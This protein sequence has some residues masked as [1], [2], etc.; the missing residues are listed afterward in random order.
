MLENY[1]K[2]ISFLKTNTFVFK[3]VKNKVNYHLTTTLFLLFGLFGMTNAFGQSPFIDNNSAAPNTFTVP[4]GVTSITIQLWGGGGAGGGSTTNGSG[5][6]GGGSGGY[7][8]RTYAGLTGGEVINYTL[9]NGGTGS[10]GNGTNG[11]DSTLTFGGFTLTANGGTGGGANQGAIGTGG[12]ASGGTTNTSSGTI[13]YEDCITCSGDTFTQS[14][15][16]A[17]YSNA[18]GR[19]VVQVDSVALGGFNGLN[20]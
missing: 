9:G 5:G 14:L 13:V 10:T 7:T 15:P 19:S 16:H 18:Q 3:N 1:L 4:Q 2:K 17:I 11:F 8:T 6:S 20:S 12:T